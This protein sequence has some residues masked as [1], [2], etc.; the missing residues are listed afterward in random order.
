MPSLPTNTPIRSSPRGSAAGPSCKIEPSA[1]HGFEA[2]DMIDRD[3]VLERV[4]AAGVRGHVAADGAGALA[5]WIGGEVV[6]GAGQRRVSR[7]L[8]TPASTTAMRLRRSISRIL[9][10][11]VSMTTTA[12]P[13]RGSHRQAA[14]GQAGAGATGDD[15]RARA[16][17]KA[18]RL[19]HLLG[20][21][22]K[23][24]RL[25]RMTLDRE[26][27]AIVDGQLRRR[28]EHILWP[29]GFAEIGD[30]W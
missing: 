1:K 2:E 4:R 3:A 18:H 29:E 11:R 21:T 8:A 27:V 10:I 12:P 26:G 20:G 13:R 9:F 14:A 22:R 16:G 6:A 24:H 28:R 23:D 15:R 5:R 19:G 30:Q 17:D 7:R 25:G